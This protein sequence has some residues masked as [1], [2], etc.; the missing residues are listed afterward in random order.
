[1]VA[2][3]FCVFPL[4]DYVGSKF[5]DT[6]ITKVFDLCAVWVAIV[7]KLVKENVNL[8]FFVKNLSLVLPNILRGKL[9]LSRTDVVLILNEGCV[10]HDA[11]NH[12]LRESFVVENYLCIA[13]H[14][15]RKSLLICQKHVD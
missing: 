8:E 15:E 11:A 12:G 6:F 2:N 9:H 1:M 13:A 14:C 5:L 7:T 4:L 10:E 3:H